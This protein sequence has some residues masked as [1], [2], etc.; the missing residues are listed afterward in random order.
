MGEILDLDGLLAAVDHD[1]T[2]AEVAGQRIRQRGVTLP[3]VIELLKEFP[4]LKKLVDTL[5]AGSPQ[6]LQAL[7]DATI[8]RLMVDA[9][10]MDGAG[11][12]CAAI[13]LS[14]LG[15]RS[16][17]HEAKLARAP[18]KVLGGLLDGLFK[19]TFPEGVSSFF[20]P[21]AGVLA[22]MGMVPAA[23][24]PAPETISAD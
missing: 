2:V 6:D 23:E 9:A 10:L 7:D 20:A 22:A 4:R 1:W 14:T 12:A 24:A 18:D 5:Y 11:A 17:E 15:E 8:G 3:E 19:R 16:P 13:A 21:Y